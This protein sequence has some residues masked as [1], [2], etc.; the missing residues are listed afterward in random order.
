MDRACSANRVEEECIWDIGGRVRRKEITGKT[1]TYVG[2]QYK[3]GSYGD[4]MGW[5]G[6]D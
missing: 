5:Y 3:N 6:L 2:G 4:R 1:K